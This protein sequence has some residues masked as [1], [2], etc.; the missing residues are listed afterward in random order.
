MLFNAIETHPE[1]QIQVNL[2]AQIISVNTTELSEQF[3][4]DAYKKTCMIH[5]YDDIDYLLS[6]KET[7]EAFEAQKQY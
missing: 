4:I 2:E 6:K 5:G 7:I 1:T 3:E